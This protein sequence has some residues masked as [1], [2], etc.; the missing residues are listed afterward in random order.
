MRADRAIDTRAIFGRRAYDLSAELL[1]L[2]IVAEAEV[3]H[4]VQSLNTQCKKLPISGE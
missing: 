3:D 2:S 4:D 1:K